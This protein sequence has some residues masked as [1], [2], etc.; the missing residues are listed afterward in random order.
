M[1]QKNSKNNE[2]IHLI[3]AIK[4]ILNRTKSNSSSTSISSRSYNWEIVEVMGTFNLQGKKKGEWETKKVKS[5]SQIR[6][7]LNFF[8]LHDWMG[9]PLYHYL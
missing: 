3:N 4:Y 9:T 5:L 8:F 1:K 6:T 7:Q 2:I